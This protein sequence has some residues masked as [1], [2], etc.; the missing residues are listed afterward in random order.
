MPT[1]PAIPAATGLSA[2]TNGDETELLVSLDETTWTAVAEIDELPDLP[3]GEQSTYETTHMKSAAFKEFK[4]N[5]R[6]EGTET[7]ITGNYVIGG[8]A[9][10]TLLAMEAA[11]GSLAYQIVL[12]Q[13][14]EVWRA[15]GRA[16]FYNLQRSNPM[17]EKRRFTITAK[18]V[19][20]MTLAK[21]A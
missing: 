5:K 1:T 7:E 15:T 10:T 13:G 17:E 12:K 3:A 6:R 9:E 2:A 11:G 18:W 20:G 4:K 16:L 8:A 21:D 14:A 19:T